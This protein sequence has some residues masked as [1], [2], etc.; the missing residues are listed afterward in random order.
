MRQVLCSQL[1]GR[2]EAT[3][4]AILKI[5]AKGLP[6]IPWST[7]D[8][9][10]VGSWLA[11]TGLSQYPISIGVVSVAARKIPPPQAALAAIR[12]SPAIS[13]TAQSA[14]PIAGR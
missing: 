12:T 13:T 1:I 8:P 6:V 3:D 14:K 7:D 10:P 2:D 11:T 5:D 4:L 9:P